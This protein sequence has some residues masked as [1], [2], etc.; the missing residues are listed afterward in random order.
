[1]IKSEIQEELDKFEE[2]VLRMTKS[3]MEE[4]GL[5]TSLFVL[6]KDLK[7]GDIEIAYADVGPFIEHDQKELLARITP[8]LV[9]KLCNDTNSAPLAF[10]FA[11]EA[12]ARQ[13]PKEK[14]IPPEFFKTE[15]YQKAPKR[16]VLLTTFETEYSVKTIMRD[17]DRDG[18]SITVQEPETLDLKESGGRFSNLFC[19]YKINKN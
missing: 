8:L 5:S 1:M 6:K 7:T 9:E 13:F 18:D 19:K 16:E 12:W 15:E 17:V 4:G 10:S 14:E 3:S 11:S 2:E